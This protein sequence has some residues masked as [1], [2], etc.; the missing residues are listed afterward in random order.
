MRT[1]KSSPS[2]KSENGNGASVRST[3]SSTAVP[4]VKFEPPPSHPT[5]NPKA[6]KTAIAAI[7]FFMIRP[8][9]STLLHGCQLRNRRANKVDFAVTESEYHSVF[10]P[11]I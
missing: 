3:V 2:C 10:H 7:A 1:T 8:S 4:R 5:A 11:D 9:E 6:I